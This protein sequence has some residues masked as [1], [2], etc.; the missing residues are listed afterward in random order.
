MMVLVPV[1]VAG[2]SGLTEV[3]GIAAKGK[4]SVDDL[5]K[6]RMAGL[7]RARRTE[8]EDGG[9]VGVGVLEVVIGGAVIKVLVGNAV[10]EAGVG[11]RVDEG[12]V[13]N[14]LVEDVGEVCGVANV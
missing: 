4:S 14:E 5:P 7:T 2:T 13:V 6:T 1:A 8:V 10:V 12:G 3:K 9:S 11:V